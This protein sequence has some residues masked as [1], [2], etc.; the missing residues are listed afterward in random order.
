MCLARPVSNN[1]R[2][3]T[4]NGL[5]VLCLTDCKPLLPACGLDNCNRWVFG[6]N[7]VSVVWAAWLSGASNPRKLQQPHR[8]WKMGTVV[9]S[10]T[11]G[12]CK[13]IYKHPCVYLQYI[14]TQ[15]GGPWPKASEVALS[16]GLPLRNT[17]ERID[18]ISR[19]SSD[20]FHDAIGMP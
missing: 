4:V 11:W 16:S 6:T 19:C 13:H 20:K 17:K 8:Y 14:H 5:Q 2:C 10:Q 3:L 9:K 12:G 15:M 7:K 1:F 18:Q